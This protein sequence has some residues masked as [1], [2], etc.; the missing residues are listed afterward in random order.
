MLIQYRCQNAENLRGVCFP[1]HLEIAQIRLLLE[2]TTAAV[3]QQL[4]KKILSHH[5]IH[6][7]LT[8][9]G[10]QKLDTAI[11]KSWE[12]REMSKNQIRSKQCVILEV[13]QLSQRLCTS[14]QLV[15]KASGNL[16]FIILSSN[17]VLYN[18]RFTQRAVEMY[19]KQLHKH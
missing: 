19:L 17:V 8:R 18:I 2:Q 7:F 14:L 3:C 6:H 16:T 13:P 15:R 11:E 5:L 9:E 1:C 10:F 4:G 12:V